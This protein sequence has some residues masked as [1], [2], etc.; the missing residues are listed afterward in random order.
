MKSKEVDTHTLERSWRRRDAACQSGQGRA[1]G[2]R[3]RMRRRGG[4]AP[5]PRHQ[6]SWHLRTLPK[7]RKPT[8]PPFTWLQEQTPKRLD[9][10]YFH[11]DLICLTMQSEKRSFILTLLLLADAS[12]KQKLAV[13]SSASAFWTAISSVP[14]FFLGLHSDKKDDLFGRPLGTLPRRDRRLKKSRRSSERS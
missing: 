2:T 9:D 13:V 6:K 11:H 3:T 5:P 4:S 8:T 14:L 1:A 7:S 10:S 12:P